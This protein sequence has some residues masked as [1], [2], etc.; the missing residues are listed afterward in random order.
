MFYP[1]NLDAKFV[2]E[3][4]FH[5]A[6]RKQ[7]FPTLGVQRDTQRVVPIHHTSSDSQANDK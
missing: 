4:V 6:N 5:G 1:P 3:Q 2:V 7:G